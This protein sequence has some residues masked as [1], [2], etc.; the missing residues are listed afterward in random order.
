[1]SGAEGVVWWAAVRWSR[2]TEQQGGRGWG[3]RVAA[4]AAARWSGLRLCPVLCARCS[5]RSALRVPAEPVPLAVGGR[6]QATAEDRDSPHVVIHH[7]YPSS[8]TASTSTP[9]CCPPRHAL[10]RSLLATLSP[11]ARCLPRCSSQWWARPCRNAA[12]PCQKQSTAPRP[13]LPQPHHSTSSPQALSLCLSLCLSLSVHS[14]GAPITL[15]PRP[16][17]Q[18]RSPLHPTSHQT[19]P[20]LLPPPPTGSRR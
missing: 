13:R 19:P 16:R 14:T 3:C 4:A 20:R 2:H 6:R 1:V 10:G 5:V 12:V 7:P 18:Q 8:S 9:A 17:A 11:P 15:S